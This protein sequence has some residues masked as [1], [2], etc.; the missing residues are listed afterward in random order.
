MGTPSKP[1]HREKEK[2][3]KLPLLPLAV[4]KIYAYV[5]FASQSSLREN[6]QGEV[7]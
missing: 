5:M 6:F 1:S 7:N 2:R 4:G 3:S